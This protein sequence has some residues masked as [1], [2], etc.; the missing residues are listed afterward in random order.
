ML[1]PSTTQRLRQRLLAWAAV[2]RADR[3]FPQWPLAVL[4]ALGSRW[5]LQALPA[6]SMHTVLGDLVQGR[7]D[8]PPG[9]LPPLLIGAGMLL[10][11]LGLLMRSRLA[12]TLALLLSL[13]ALT[14]VAIGQAPHGLHALIYFAVLPLLL[15]SAWRRFDHSSLTSGTLFAL[16]S[17]AMLLLY[18][19][20]GAYYQGSTFRPQIAD[21]P[22]ALYFAVVTMSTVGY[23]DITPQ[24]ADARLFTVS[25]IVLG[26][27]VFATSLTAVVAPMVSR[28]LQRIV[29]HK[30]RRM[31]RES[32]FV[33]VGDTPLA[34]NTWRELRRRGQPVT[35]LLRRAPDN[36]LPA[37]VDAVYGDPSDGDVLRQAGADKAQAVMAM[38]DND[39]DNAFVVLAVREIA[40]GVR[41]V[42]AVNNA[43]YLGRVKLAQPDVLIAPQILGGELVAMLMTG[44]EINADF[45]LHSV[46][47]TPEA[48][49]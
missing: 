14:S 21:L 9:S 1:R 19:T 29:N 48:S 23:G 13:T 43:S 16:T 33:V 36:A 7:H 45:V 20:F 49:A 10:S 26:V 44:E 35:R 17:V 28:S 32:H 25:I 31:K 11:A 37:D 2:A 38:L 30:G 27:A 5:L 47:Q 39:S 40:K 12:W 46:F 42:A 4:L 3:W 15:L 34:V 41:T 18:A 22:T 6:G 24:T 8:L